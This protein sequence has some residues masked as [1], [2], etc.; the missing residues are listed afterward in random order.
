LQAICKIQLLREPPIV[1]PATLSRA[2]DRAVSPEKTRSLV[3][4]DLRGEPVPGSL[5][6]ET[7]VSMGRLLGGAL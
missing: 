4:E 6:E 2:R 1:S 3:F 5:P 7:N